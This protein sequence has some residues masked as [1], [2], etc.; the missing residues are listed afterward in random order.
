MDQYVTGHCI[1]YS[2]C[3]GV[4]LSYYKDYSNNYM[5]EE[6]IQSPCA[7]LSY[8]IPQVR[9]GLQLFSLTISLK[10]TY[11]IP[12]LCPLSLLLQNAGDYLT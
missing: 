9:V 1:W 8:T 2:G 5:K 11:T 3:S 7:V 12:V 4:V 6:A 10:I